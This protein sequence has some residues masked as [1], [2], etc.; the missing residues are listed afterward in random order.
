LPRAE[1]ARFRKALLEQAGPNPACADCGVRGKR[2]QA[3]HETQTTGRLLCQGCH[4][5]RTQANQF[6]GNPPPLP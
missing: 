5:R 4:N 2:L 1:Q 6:N 3:H